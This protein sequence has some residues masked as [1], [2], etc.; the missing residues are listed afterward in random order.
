M[1][2]L[3]IKIILTVFVCLVLGYGYVR[4]FKGIALDTSIIVLLISLGLYAFFAD[5]TS[6]FG[7]V[8]KAIVLTIVAIL[9]IIQ[10]MD[11]L[12]VLCFGYHVD[13]IIGDAIAIVLATN[14]REIFSF[15]QNFQSFGFILALVS[16]LTV[17]GYIVAFN[18]KSNININYEIDKY[19]FIIICLSTMTIVVN[20]KS[21]VRILGA[22]IYKQ[23]NNMV[24][25]QKYIEAK[26]KFIWN[27]NSTVDGKSTV[28]IVL[29]ETTRGDHM[30]INGYERN[31]TPLLAKE[32]LISFKNAISNSMHTLGAT[33]FM[34]TRKPV[35]DEWV[36]KIYPE[37]SII[38]AFKEAGYTTYY[39]SYLGNVHIGDNEINQIVNEAD[40]YIRR[41]SG[42]SDCSQ[43]SQGLPIIKNILDKDKSEKRLII[44]KL[45]GSHWHFQD[46]YPDKFDNFQPSFRTTEFK[47]PNLAQKDIFVN[48]YDN[49]IMHTDYVVSH[50]IGYLKSEEGECS[51]SLLSDH[52]ISLYEDNKTLYTGSAKANYNIAYFFWLN[53]NVQDRLGQENIEV[54]KNNTDKPVDQTS[55]IDT[56]FIISGIDSEK[57]VGISLFDDLS[58]K[59]ERRV[60]IGNKIVDYK[61]IYD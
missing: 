14:N 35:T 51:L 19:L 41:P 16:A 23:V 27:A 10:C 58:D 5:R 42:D 12:A 60:L 36:N 55:F 22:E 47:G 29:G 45:M 20:V 56:M 15:I 49:S 48:S 53:D 13:G 61:S 11:Q 4:W 43:D 57:K 24:D 28:V 21:P 34:L 39:I 54:L 44:Y 25:T 26:S 59:D 1:N 3:Y 52:G 37:K 40:Y 32:N 2:K 18:I 46:T 7:G 9:G 6:I 33:P 31:T 30:S 17:V 38:S 50:I 8:K